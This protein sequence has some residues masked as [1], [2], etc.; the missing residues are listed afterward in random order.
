M[1]SY[2]PAEKSVGGQTCQF[3]Q[4]KNLSVLCFAARFNAVPFAYS[5]FGTAHRTALIILTKTFSLGSKFQRPN[6][7]QQLLRRNV[8][9]QVR[10]EA[11]EATQSGGWRRALRL[12]KVESRYAAGL[13]EQP[14]DHSEGYTGYMLMPPDLQ[15]PVT[16]AELSDRL[17]AV[18]KL[19]DAFD[20][21]ARTQLNSSE[22]LLFHL[23]YRKRLTGDKAADQLGISPEALRKQWSRLLN[24]VLS[25][26][27]LQLQR[28]P[29][30][31]ELLGEILSNE[32][33]FRRTLLQFLRLVMQKGVEELEK[34]VG[35]T[36][37]N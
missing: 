15:T 22:T 2:L 32:K 12:G 6:C 37:K 11:Q 5:V 28:D 13:L 31:N 18:K 7:H 34:F 36:L 29:L 27:R 25:S 35:T 21:A 20:F 30:C 3:W 23:L 19:L 8:L 24:K 33:T 10:H 26:V 16:G 9:A 4:V 17:A 14:E 1:K